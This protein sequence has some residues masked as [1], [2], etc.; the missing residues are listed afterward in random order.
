MQDSTDL[1]CRHC[2]EPLRH[3]YY[4]QGNSGEF[5]FYRCAVCTLVN[6]DMSGGLDQTK[7][8]VEF[9]D[10][11]D[12]SLAKNRNQT[13]TNRFLRRQLSPPGRLLEIGCGN[14]RLLHLARL[15]GW[16]VT[17][18][19]LSPFLATRVTKRLGVP[20]IQANIGD[21]AMTTLLGSGTFDVI[22]LRH[23]L[24]HLPDPNAAIALL[25]S[26][27]PEGGHVLFEFPNI[28]SLVMKARRALQGLGLFR[29]TYPEGYRPGHVHE[30]CRESFQHVVDR[31]GFEVV[32]WETCSR[33]P[34]RD[35]IFA[36]WPVG[37]KVRTLVRKRLAAG[38][39][40]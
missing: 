26:L 15:D 33:D 27:L 24:E 21:P 32:V 8:A 23:V 5:R 40:A 20:V 29:K 37:T 9:P 36:R 18:V 28:E 7:Y 3:L 30:Y 12:D 35:W 17:G 22:V 38:I 39:C 19:E 14:G 6:Y 2:G 13:V 31:T 11:E 25:H 34:V 10:P 4:T 1:R 16:S